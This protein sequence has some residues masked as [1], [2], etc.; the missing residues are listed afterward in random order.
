MDADR[1][2]ISGKYKLKGNYFNSQRNYL[3]KEAKNMGF[4]VIDF[5]EEF[6]RKYNQGF[7]LNSKVD[8]H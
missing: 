3:M 4:T 5:E 8:G 2:Y 7:S 1:G 6:T